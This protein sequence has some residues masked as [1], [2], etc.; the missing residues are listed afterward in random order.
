MI[1]GCGMAMSSKCLIKREIEH[2]VI[3]ISTLPLRIEDIFPLGAM[4]F[5]PHF[6]V[7]V[8]T[9]SRNSD[10]DFVQ[11]AADRFQI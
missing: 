6:N 5:L 8:L 1:Y 9:K 3:T 7:T 11:G 10:R 2:N 4:G